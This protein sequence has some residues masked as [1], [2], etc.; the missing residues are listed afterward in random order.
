M[1]FQFMQSRGN[2]LDVAIIATDS[3]FQ[4]HRIVSNAIELISTD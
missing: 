4:W 1:F 2:N 3:W